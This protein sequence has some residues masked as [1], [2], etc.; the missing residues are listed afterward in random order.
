MIKRSNRKTFANWIRTNFR[1][2][3]TMKILCSDEK[4]FDIDGVDNSQNDRMWAED[5]AD[6]DKKDGIKQRRKFPQKVMV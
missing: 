3:E 4:F 5:C 1:K 6:A 2:E